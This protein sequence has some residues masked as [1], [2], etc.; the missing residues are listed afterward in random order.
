MEVQDRITFSMLFKEAVA[1][2]NQSQNKPIKKEFVKAVEESFKYEI[3]PS[4]ATCL[5]FY[6]EVLKTIE[7]KH[8]D[9]L[10]EKIMK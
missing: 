6:S 7:D 8:K 4:H 9:D 1:R 3:L 5:E 2:V 10:M